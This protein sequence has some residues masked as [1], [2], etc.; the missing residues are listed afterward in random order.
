MTRDHR[1]RLRQQLVKHEGLRLR[2]YKDTVGKLTIG[3]GRNIED[4]GISEGEAFVLL[5]NDI[6]ECLW[7]L[8]YTFPW[9]ERL[10]PMRQRVWIDLC[11]N[12]GITRLQTFEKAIAAMEN[13]DYQEA[14][15]QLHDSKWCGQVGKRADWLIQALITG[16]EPPR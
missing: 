11:F 8:S 2:P 13:G 15:A 9:F 16:A 7:Q 1:E 12:M 14:A 3:V 10:D 4:R 6:S 5:D